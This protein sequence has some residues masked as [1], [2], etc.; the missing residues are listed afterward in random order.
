MI[1]DLI[2]TIQNQKEYIL[3]FNFIINMNK[4]NYKIL[5]IRNSVII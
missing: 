1:S 2:I 3:I 5:D 4:I